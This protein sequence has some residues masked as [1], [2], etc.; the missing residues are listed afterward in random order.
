MDFSKISQDVFNKQLEATKAWHACEPSSFADMD[1]ADL[2]LHQHWCN[3]QLWHIE[4]EAR[5]KDVE[6]KVIADCKYAID[7]LNQKRN[8]YMEKVDAAWLK[9]LAPHLPAQAKA[10]Y[11]TES[12]GMAC[13]RMSILALKLWHMQEQM[14]RTNVG[15]E[16]VASCA[17]KLQVLQEQRQDLAL[18]INFL[19]TE[20]IQGTKQPKLYF[21]FKMYN[22]PNLNPQLYAKA[23]A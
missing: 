18:A 2:I 6:P 16:H 23:G 15:V 17:K 9:L 10:V 4:D 1:L 20:F 21:Q 14:E 8:D 3:F 5:R 12:L 19:L 11:N 13:D 22:D 7:G